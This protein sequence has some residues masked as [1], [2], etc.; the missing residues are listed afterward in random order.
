MYS[1]GWI[2]LTTLLPL[3]CFAVPV[4][5]LNAR[6]AKAFLE[7]V[8]ERTPQVGGQKESVSINGPPGTPTLSQILL[9]R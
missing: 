7:T 2:N 4:P 5:H 6:V 1:N 9:S 3:S 8:P